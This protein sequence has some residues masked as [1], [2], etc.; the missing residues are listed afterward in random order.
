MY[1]DPIADL[2]T[3]IRN[4]LSAHART[5]QVPHSEIKEQLVTLMRQ[6]GFLDACRVL[7]NGPRKMLEVDLKYGPK[8]EPIIRGLKRISRP[9]RREYVGLAKM[10]PLRSGQGMRLLS[11]PKG[12]MTDVRARDEKVGGEAICE[13]W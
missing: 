4:G 2:L 1:T 12:V 13:I 10:K 5:V 6:E 8:G 9:S 7:K 3:R 11:T